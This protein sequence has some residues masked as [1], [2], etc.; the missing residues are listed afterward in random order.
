MPD[1]MKKEP[2][3]YILVIL[4]LAILTAEIHMQEI[5][6][7]E[8]LTLLMQLHLDMTTIGTI[9]HEHMLHLPT[10]SEVPRLPMR[11]TGEG[12][13]QPEHM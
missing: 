9:Q 6:M 12:V 1:N 5:P 13:L 4:M 2:E 7:E 8:I 10:E 11:R 3:P